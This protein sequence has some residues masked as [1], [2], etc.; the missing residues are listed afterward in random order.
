MTT[1][2]R[3]RV[4]ERPEVGTEDRVPRTVGPPSRSAGEADP[5]RLALIDPPAERTTL[6]GAAWPR[7]RSLSDDL[8]GLVLELRRRG[9]RVT[10]GGLQP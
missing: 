10:R 8:P 3:R 5:V 1:I 9:I 6:D 7:T 4:P 2:R